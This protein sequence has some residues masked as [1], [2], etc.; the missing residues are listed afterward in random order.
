MD[1]QNLTLRQTVHL[2][3]PLASI[4]AWRASIHWKALLHGQLVSDHLIEHPTLH[5]TLVH[6]KEEAKDKEAFADRGWQDAIL[7]VYPL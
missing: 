6:V 7:S 1:F 3:P 2:E 4:P 5:V